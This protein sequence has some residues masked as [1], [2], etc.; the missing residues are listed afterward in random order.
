MTRW[1]KPVTAHRPDAL[2]E[3]ERRR[4]RAGRVLLAVVAAGVLFAL[5]PLGGLPIILA[6]PGIGLALAW[7]VPADREVR[8]GWGFQARRPDRIRRNA[9]IVA[10]VLI[11]NAVLLLQPELLGF[12]IGVFGLDG[13][14]LVVTLLAVA[15]LALPLALRTSPRPPDDPPAPGWVL[16]QRAIMLALTL[17]VTAAI[18]YATIGQSFMLLAVL[19]PL[20]PL[21]LLAGRVWAA[22]QGRVVSLWRRDRWRR[23]MRAQWVAQ[24]WQLLNALVL[25]GLLVAATLPGTFDVL[26]LGMP[27]GQYRAFQIAYLAGAFAFIL[28]A[29]IPLRR[30]HL[31]GNLAMLAGS[32]FI[33]V[34]LV[35][36]YRPPAQSVPIVSPLAVRWY[37]AQGG[38]AELVNYHHVTSTQRDALDIVQ[39]V[40]GTTHRPGSSTTAPESFY[41]FGADVLAPAGGT[42]TDVVDGHPDLAV[43]TVDNEHQGGNH[44]VI[45]VGG[46]RYLEFSHLRQGS[47]HVVEGDVVHVG[48]VIA[49]VG[50]SGNTDQPHLHIQAMNQPAFP[51]AI[52]DIRDPA[53]LLRTLRTY[54]L[55]VRDVALTRSG[56]RSTPAAADPRRGDQIRPLP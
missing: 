23:P 24:R 15:V 17:T 41:I 7:G 32:V 47:I 56:H 42:V 4:R 46:G 51:D 31:A 8:S 44:I 55:T 40:S 39:V 5:I 18:W 36:I 26:R 52:H 34:Q 28:L 53:G 6:V 3:P 33:G 50:N 30:V 48:Q 10:A 11:G 13:Y 21:L 38:H 27:A 2:A 43:G 25:A 14:E 12:L 29:T 1:T 35:M 37:V 19:V 49:Q 20:A 16:T 54:P 22:R 45:D 9:V